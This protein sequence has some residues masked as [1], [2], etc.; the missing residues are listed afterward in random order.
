MATQQQIVG[1][2]A[3]VVV[4][5]VIIGGGLAFAAKDAEPGDA[6]YSLRASLYG[7]NDYSVDADLKAAG[8]TYDEA[9]ALQN[10]GQLTVSERARLSAAYAARVNAVMRVI[11]ELEADG[12]TEEALRIR[13]LLRAQ[14]RASNDLFPSSSNDDASSSAAASSETTSVTPAAAATS[15]AASTQTASAPAMAPASEASSY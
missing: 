1:T 13:A 9:V 3:A 12:N 2:V 5:V 8:E 7:D 11:A 10:S 4:A 14:L 6:L 15:T